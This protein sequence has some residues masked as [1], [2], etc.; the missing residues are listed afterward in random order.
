M[1]ENYDAEELG[2]IISSVWMDGP[3]IG[4]ETAEMEIEGY[5]KGG[6]CGIALRELLM[7]ANVMNLLLETLHEFSNEGYG[8]HLVDDH[9]MK[10]GQR[11]PFGFELKGDGEFG[12]GEFYTPNEHFSF[13]NISG[14]KGVVALMNRC[15]IP[16]TPTTQLLFQEEGALQSK[17][18]IRT[19]LPSADE[20]TVASLLW[21]EVYEKD[22]K[23]FLGNGHPVTEK[24]G[25]GRIV[26]GV[27]MAPNSPA[28]LTG[29]SVVLFQS[30]DA[31]VN[32]PYDNI[33]DNMNWGLNKR[34][35]SLV[36]D[37]V[38][39]VREIP[40]LRYVVS[41][42][43][44]MLGIKELP[45]TLHTCEGLTSVIYLELGTVLRELPEAI[46]GE[47]GKKG[48][49]EWVIPFI[50]EQLKT[51]F[52]VGYPVE[53]TDLIY[54]L[55]RDIRDLW[56][57]ALAL[58]YY[59]PNAFHADRFEDLAHPE[60]YKWNYDIRDYSFDKN[61]DTANPL[62]NLIGAATVAMYK[63][64][65]EVVDSFPATMSGVDDR[66][67][68]ARKA[69]N[70]L[71]SPFD[72]ILNLLSGL[73]EGETEFPL[74]D[75][76]DKNA[77][78]LVDMF[79]PIIEMESKGIVDSVMELVCLLGKPSLSDARIKIGEGLAEVISTTKDGDSI[80]PFTFAAEILECSDK[81]KEDP[82]RWDLFKQSLDA[83]EK[84]LSEDSPYQIVDTLV[85]LVNHLT[86]VEVS[87]E[88]WALAT[89]GIVEVLAKSTKEKVFTR[90]A[91]HLTTILDAVDT[92][93]IWTDSLHLMNDELSPGGL[94]D[95]IIKGMKKDPNYT[96]DEILND[97]NRF[98]KS[99]LMME[100]EEG[101]FWKDVYYL[102]D[103]LVGALE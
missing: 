92:K 79:E 40:A 34:K 86:S 33:Y 96:W 67:E 89:E 20:L 68:A 13:K 25:Y 28:L 46:A 70:G 95:Y 77:M 80:A 37:L 44:S 72:Y 97:T 47:V 74:Y 43:F 29:G 60:N 32:G 15:N 39:I 45:V 31:L 9:L 2:G 71:V 94:I 8:M 49:P 38:Q 19:L 48:L 73:Y 17:K 58:A 75:F 83:L 61:K 103:F 53:G 36:L 56:T 65:T 30:G 98:F 91:I 24:R 55:P 42:V 100:Y 41:P 6:S 81:A 1:N 10:M 66:Q 84:F 16:F 12:S 4:P 21:A 50:V 23:A 22:P 54:L 76:V 27:F 5:G 99:D 93:H 57:L 18:L 11:D 59:D 101:A 7:D 82:R 69:F 64:Y 90:S 35:F 85:G 3:F 63:A 14:I 62:F 52:L 87:D 78:P 88:D 26:D 102:I 51:N